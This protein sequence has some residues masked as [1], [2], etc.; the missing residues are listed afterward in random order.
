[1]NK[2]LCHSLLLAF[3]LCGLCLPVIAQTR[4]SQSFDIDDKQLP[5]FA[6]HISD[7]YF[8]DL[9]EPVS[10]RLLRYISYS[11]QLTHP[12]PGQKASWSFIQGLNTLNIISLLKQLERDSAVN[13][14]AE[15][16]KYNVLLR[17]SFENAIHYD[18]QEKQLSASMYATMQRALEGDA[19]IE[20]MKNEL[21]L[22]GNG[23]SETSYW[24]KH[25][26]VIGELEQAGRH[27]EAMQAS[28]K[29]K[30]EMSQAGVKHPALTQLQ[31]RV[32]QSLA[33]PKQNPLAQ[34]SSNASQSR[35]RQPSKVEIF[36]SE[37]WPL[38]IINLVIFGFIIFAAFHTF[39]RKK[40]DD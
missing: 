2:S 19:K 37:Y 28:Q 22:G 20:A 33:S 17:K 30:Q 25:W 8:E 9:S 16:A 10:T 13:N 3:L 24:F 4:F 5:T 15:I 27:E 1:M 35:H 31:A 11:D 32:D 12:E 6:D 18:S 40:T 39:F 38:I 7:E 29:M 23:D 21:Q 36:I 14:Q 34:P 26:Q